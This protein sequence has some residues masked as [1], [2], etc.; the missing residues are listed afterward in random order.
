MLRLRKRDLPPTPVEP[1]KAP[2]QPPEWVALAQQIKDL[3]ARLALMHKDIGTTSPDPKLEQV[4]ELL[5]AAPMQQVSTPAGTGSEWVFEVK[6]GTY[7]EIL[8][9]YA[10]R[11]PVGLKGLKA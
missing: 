9:V 5:Q 3:Q 11:V 1:P 4:L 6:R 8:N 2:V 10:R 7:N